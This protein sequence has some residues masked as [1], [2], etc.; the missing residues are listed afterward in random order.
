MFAGGLYDH[1]S[2]DSLLDPTYG[3]DELR[4]PDGGGGVEGGVSLTN[5]SHDSGLTTSDSQLYAA[6][7]T[8]SFSSDDFTI[9]TIS[10]HDNTVHAI[11]N[12][13]FL[14]RYHASYLG[15]YQD[16]KAGPA[17]HASPARRK[18]NQRSAKHRDRMH[19][20]IH[21]NSEYTT[22]FVGSKAGLYILTKRTR[23]PSP[24]VY[25]HFPPNSSRFPMLL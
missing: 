16:D 21:R 1:S 20:R 19:R 15:Q 7:E 13:K 5:L 10:G 18:L 22:S 14:S 6:E 25:I 9:E 4:S 12:K 24:K 8:G 17:D 11:V 2:L 3:E 23:L